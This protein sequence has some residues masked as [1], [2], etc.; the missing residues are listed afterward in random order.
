MIEVESGSLDL[1]CKL[2]QDVLSRKQS[3]SGKPSHSAIKILLVIHQRAA[4]SSWS[5]SKASQQM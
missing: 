2:D 4:F 5:T 1:L 3:I